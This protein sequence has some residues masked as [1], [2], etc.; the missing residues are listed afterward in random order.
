MITVLVLEVAPFIRLNKEIFPYP[1][2]FTY[3]LNR[4]ID[5][6]RVGVLF[7]PSMSREFKKLTY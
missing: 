1:L 7:A 4:I 3:I 2:Y 6:K 5:V